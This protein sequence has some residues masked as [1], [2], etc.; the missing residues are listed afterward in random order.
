[1]TLGIVADEISRDFAT[2]VEIGKRAGLLRYEIRNLKSGRVPLCDPHE[3]D[4]VDRIIQGEG[5]KITTISPGLFKYTDDAAG[6]AREM[7]EMYPR[8]VELAERWGLAT[9][10]IFGFHKPGATEANAATIS[11][12]NPPPA[13]AE[14]LAVACERAHDDHLTL[15]I[16]PEPICWADTASA[17]VSMIQTA[18]ARSVKINCDPGNVAW[19]WNRDPLEDLEASID[20]VRNVHVKDLRPLTRGA[21][22]PEWIPAGQGMINYRAHFAALR[23]SGF[24]GNYS[25]EPHMDGTL[26]TIQAC[27]QAFER[28]FS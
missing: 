7:A 11:S 4:E 2:A 9:M 6:F 25:L 5:V 13:V 27:K 17:A 22:H 1:M 8:A 15:L 12:S 28:E 26:E 20:W 21:A 14:W 10:I 16:E 23:G 19:L 3:L 24:D 18:H